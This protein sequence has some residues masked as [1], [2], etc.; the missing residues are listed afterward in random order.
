MSK[1]G[2]GAGL[3][4]VAVGI[5]MKT[6]VLGNGGD[7]DPEDVSF[8]P[9]TG[10]L[11]FALVSA[12]VLLGTGD[13]TPAEEPEAAAPPRAPAFDPDAE[14]RAPD[15]RSAEQIET[16]AKATARAGNC[17]TALR[18]TDELRA[19]DPERHARLQRDAAIARCATPPAP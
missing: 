15:H 18:L 2:I 11:I 14:G 10:G 17:R 16:Q 4:L 6:G 3:G 5:G 13:D 19:I 8:I 7:T 12:L 9:I 1:V